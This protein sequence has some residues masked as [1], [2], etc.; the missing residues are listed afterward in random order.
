[1]DTEIG[2]ELDD[3]SIKKA[4]FTW[5]GEN[6]TKSVGYE[7]RKKIKLQ[8][9]LEDSKNFIDKVE[10]ESKIKLIEKSCFRR[11]AKVNSFWKSD[12]RRS[13]GSRSL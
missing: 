8:D 4:L 5:N 6:N 1:M 11:G 10:T 12:F 2:L 9:I 13:G 7:I 3:W